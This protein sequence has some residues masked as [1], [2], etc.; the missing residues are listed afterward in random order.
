MGMPLNSDMYRDC[1]REL[2]PGPKPEASGARALEIRDPVDLPGLA[3]VGRKSLFPVSRRCGDIRP[4]EAHANRFAA[5]GIVGK[6]S[7]HTILEA[8]FDG[9]IKIAERRAPV[10]PPNGPL[11]GFRI[12]GTQR[13]ALVSASTGHVHYIFVF[14]GVAVHEDAKLCVP[15]NST[16]S[17]LPARRSFRRR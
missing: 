6:E 16:H 3:A 7:T 4:N 8:A 5:Q 11:P 12:V 10:E 9:R 1:T 2:V 14:V 13:D 15:S 17:W